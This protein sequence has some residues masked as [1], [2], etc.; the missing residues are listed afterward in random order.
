MQDGYTGDVG[1][2][3]KYGLLRALAP[4]TA[5]NE[6]YRLGVVWYRTPDEAHLADGGF[7]DY[8]LPAGEED[9][10][11]CDPDLFD[12]LRALVMGGN[13]SL[14]AVRIR[15]LLPL[16]TAFYE[17]LLSY[18]GA[19]S[20]R[21]V[22]LR[23]AWPEP[24]LAIT[25]GCDLLFLDPDNGI[26]AGAMTGEPRELKWARVDELRAYLGRGQSLVVYHHLGRSAPHVEQIESWR[27][28]LHEEFG[29]S[30]PPFAVRFTR[31]RARAFFVLP[32]DPHRDVLEQALRAFLAGPWQAF[33]RPEDAFGI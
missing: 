15:E 2:F 27:Q 3:A 25:S 11:A 16:D 6:G 31:G 21:K 1:D 5:D 24:A 7:V 8:L 33:F 30:Q 9:Y 29:L 23:A 32:A 28:T 13:R 22:A 26:H 18:A 19:G 10:R 4:P 20:G 12:R 14:S 17:S